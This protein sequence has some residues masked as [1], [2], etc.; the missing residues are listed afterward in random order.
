MKKFVLTGFGPATTEE[1]IQSWLGEFGPVVNVNIVRDGNRSAP[2]A[3]VEMDVGNVQ[4][5]RLTSRISNY[6]HEGRMVNVWKLLY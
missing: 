2:V 5:F 6:W 3:I 4:A 1:S